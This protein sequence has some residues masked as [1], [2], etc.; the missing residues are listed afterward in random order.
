MLELL[1][2]A[3][4][5]WVA[6]IL[7][8]MLIISFA[9]WGINDIF[10]G[11]S[12][13]V[14]ARVGDGEIDVR[15]F[16]NDFTTRVRQQTNADGQPMTVEEGRALGYD[17]V[18]LDSMISDMAVRQEAERLGLT[19]SDA[20]VRDAIGDIQGIKAP[21][22]SIDRETFDRVLRSINMNEADFVSVVRNDL[23]RAQLIQTA[24]VGGLPP[25]GMVM[26]EA[27][28]ANERRTI[29]YAVLP[30]GK[31]GEIA[32]PDDAALK[33]YVDAHA[34]LYTTPELRAIT[35]M[36]V[37]PDDLKAGIEVT[38][39]E[40]KKGYEAQ[41]TR[42][43]TKEKRTLQQIVYP[44][45]EAA[46]AARKELDAGKS[47]E[48][49]AAAAK[50]SADDIALGDIEKGD[51]T[52]PDGAF[53][54][55]EGEVT[56]PLEGPFGW[57]I[58]KVVKVVPGATQPYEEAAKTLREEMIHAKAL[59]KIGELSAHMQDVMSASDSL[60]TAAKDLKLALK[61]YPAIDAQGRDAD[62]KPIDGLPD[63]PAFLTDMAALQQGD[64]SFV[65]ETPEHTLYVVRADKIS[66]P[67]LKPMDA[68]RD[69][70]TRAWTEQEQLKRLTA[71]ADDLTKKANAGGMA[72]D[73][74]ATE[75]GVEGKTTAAIDRDSADG[76]LSPALKASLFASKAGTWVPG[77]GTTAP[78]MIV[79]RVKEVTSEP[80]KDAK[81]Q[82]QAL[83]SALN[84]EI[85]D[86]LSDIYRQAILAA[87]PVS[88]D[89]AMFA[90]TRRPPQ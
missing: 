16:E 27:A 21:D 38:D 1:R 63:G 33:A 37:G 47:F 55:A 88:I 84:G 8:G 15:T 50:K 53:A 36:S 81:A 66:P 76:Q 3:S 89:E 28:F 43:E 7:I 51:T 73:S 57:V 58:I 78:D 39:D 41:K 75:A 34:E 25:K 24:R 68:I 10:R 70:V 77:A 35:L 49:L 18:V 31:A 86:D 13:T 85:A 52:V 71:L 62:G 22:G 48:D 44:T 67:A 32:A 23:V 9:V 30:P 54:I 74:L 80:A 5:T 65:A 2:S 11:G 46:E 83:V 45:R 42:F 19:A 12:S 79:A 4:K 56:Q 69:A 29:E 64:M 26:I 82:Q 20:M 40:I 72:L 87:T 60:E 14:V 61:T 6:A 90:R 17:R 59:D